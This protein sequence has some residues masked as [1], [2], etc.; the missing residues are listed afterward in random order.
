MRRCLTTSNVAERHH[1]TRLQLIDYQPTRPRRSPPTKHATR[2]GGGSNYCS[3]ETSTRHGGVLSAHLALL[4][5][6]AGSS[7]IYS[8]LSKEE[9]EST[10][11][12][13]SHSE[14]IAPS[15]LGR[16]HTKS[17]L[18]VFRLRHRSKAYETYSHF[19]MPA[20][21]P[22]SKPARMTPETDY[23]TSTHRWLIPLSIHLRPLDRL[24][25][26]RRL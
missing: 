3:D 6:P 20:S 22:A 26:A 18:D 10:R 7:V 12:V 15:P 19:I 14:L 9:R 11:N 13:L 25:N 23:S 1:N 16:K 5:R 17:T 4:H 21:V 8:S 24:S 2:W